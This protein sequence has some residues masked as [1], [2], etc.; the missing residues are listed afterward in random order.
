VDA[1]SSNKGYVIDAS[2]IWSLKSEYNLICE[3]SYLSKD[4]MAIALSGSL[5]K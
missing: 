4:S 3:D 5:V 1:C 2:S